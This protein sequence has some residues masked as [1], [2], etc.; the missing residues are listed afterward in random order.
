MT[1]EIKNYYLG[2]SFDDPKDYQY[3]RIPINLI[4]QEVNDE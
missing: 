4:P 2:I 1:M 3:I